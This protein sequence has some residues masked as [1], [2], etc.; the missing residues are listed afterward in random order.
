VGHF[1]FFTPFLA[2]PFYYANPSNGWKA[3]YHLLPSFIGPRDPKILDGFFE[4]HSSFFHANVMRAW[5][6][7]L[8]V[9][10]I[11]FLALL[12]TTLC[13]ACVLRQRW[14]DEEHLP[15]PVIALPL[16]MTR[17]GAPLY[18]N[19]L[20]WCG[21][22]IPMFVHS[23]NSLQSIYP[24]LPTMQMNTTHDFISNAGL[25]TPW[26]GAGTLFYQLHPCG[27]GFGY[28]INTDVSFS[29]WFFYLLKKAVDVWAVTVNLRDAQTGWFV[30]SNG[31]FPYFNAQGYGAF[32]AL[33]VITLWIGRRYFLDYLKR[34]WRGPSGQGKMDEAMSPRTAML[35]LVGGFLALCAFVWVLGGSWWLPVL[36]F[37]V[38]VLLMVTLS[39]IRAE[40]AV[41][42]SELVWVNP[43]SMITSIL[44]TTNMS[45]ADLGHTA[46]LTWFN[47]DYRAAGMPHEL[48]GLVGMRR[49]RGRMSPLVT[50]I[51]AAAAVAMVSALIWDL[52]LYYTHGAAMGN[53]NSWRISKG[54]EPWHDLQGWLQSPQPPD[55]HM[56]WG[57][58]AGVAVTLFLSVMRANFFG[59]PLHPAAYA[60]NCTF[61]NDLFWGDMFIAWLVKCAILRYSG[62]GLYRRALPFFLGLILGDFI[63]G[64]VWSI[65]G[66]VFHLDLF[67]TF[68]T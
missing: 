66:T 15:F 51:M 64:S 3:F 46:M 5:A 26:T 44:G 68:A 9:W 43:Q 29:L 35:G 49:T 2:N 16:E 31:Q 17:E 48:E 27:V 8:T 52:Q 61:A 1:G 13:L 7:P 19:Y 67:R 4:G 57:L 65:I 39:R 63:T 47:T 33:G 14:A 38:Y 25:Q 60:L 22:A 21:F 6:C 41:L 55:Q 11:F 10:S 24:T 50:A 36:F 20:L 34:A 54:S 59:F 18:R 30:D 56:F 42:C 53:V 23:L 58:V 40:T 28:L 37:G 45:P 62:M 32:L 12:W